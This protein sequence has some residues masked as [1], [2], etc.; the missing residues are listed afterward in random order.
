MTENESTDLSKD[1]TQNPGTRLGERLMERGLLSLRQFQFALQK[2][3][4]EKLRFGTLLIRYGLVQEDAL[5]KEL[6][7]RKSI[8]FITADEFPSPDPEV[9]KHFNR[10][11]CLLNGFLPI[12]RNGDELEV[13]LGD[14][15]E[16]SVSELAMHRTGLKCRFTQGSF[17]RVTRHIRGSY[18]FTQH[19][20]ES[21]VKQEIRRL[22]GDA[23]HAVS[24]EKFL[25][26]LLHWAVRERATDI[27]LTP[28][29][30]SLH[31]FFRI[32]GVLRPMVALPPQ[33]TRLVIFIK[34]TSEI[35]ISEQ[36]RPQDGS[37]HCTILDQPFAVRVSILYTE[38]GERVVLRL[39][40]ERSDLSSLEQLGFLQED[41]ERLERIFLR[42]AGM[43]LITGPTGSGKST[44]MHAALQIQSLVENN[45]LT[46]EDPIEY[47]VPGSA[48]T[49]VNRRTGYDFGNALRFFLRHDP[50][51]I[52]IG[53]IRDAETAQAA[54]EASAT[55]HLVLSTL[56]APNVFGVVP[57]L[58]PFGLEPQ[59]IADNLVAIISQRLLRRNCP[60]CS[61]EVLLAEA[62]RRR[63]G[64]G[65][66]HARRGAGC[67]ACGSSGYFGRLPVYEI[68]E[69]NQ[70]LANLIADDAGREAI[71]RKALDS[72]FKS[73]L[74]QAKWR[75]RNGQTTL[76]EVGRVIGWSVGE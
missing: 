19:S 38:F 37:F 31:L 56:H 55:G 23:D 14:G 54:V 22:S 7:A 1:S 57:R 68:L 34:L 64:E 58:R 62:E 29:P 6:A 50:D 10:E 15:D 76:E 13:L 30:N 63:L 12:R 41:I 11:L 73:M 28:S 17:S 59:T 35:D 2:Q 75:V 40:P 67:E 39:L 48:Q 42:P 61:Q 16:A 69:L 47:R 5:V 26:Y 25:D 21:L 71:Y 9:L 32:D 60:H 65:E 3:S 33:L 8:P 49:E 45:I 18:Y 27:H 36:R 20:I 43:V 66:I 53:E 70:S 52:L 4:V 51:V 44:T 24:P 74:E 72:G 46:V